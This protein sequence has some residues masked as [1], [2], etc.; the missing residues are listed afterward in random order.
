MPAHQLSACT[1]GEWHG[2]GTQYVMANV[3]LRLHLAVIIVAS[4]LVDTHTRIHTEANAN[5]TCWRRNGYA[6]FLSF[7]AHWSLHQGAYNKLSRCKT[8]ICY[9]SLWLNGERQ[10]SAMRKSDTMALVCLC[11]SARHREKGRISQEDWEETLL[12]VNFPVFS[13]C[14]DH[15]VVAEQDFTQNSSLPSGCS[16]PL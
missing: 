1:G 9:P 15:A 8:R 10:T 13:L 2:K 14:F 3:C 7:P 16:I 6:V 5:V 11:L 12:P 4:A